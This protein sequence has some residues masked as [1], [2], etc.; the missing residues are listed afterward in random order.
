MSTS[1]NKSTSG[2]WEKENVS[3]ELS[4]KPTVFSVK[5]P[6]LIINDNVY[7][8]GFKSEEETTP[9]KTF[10]EMLYK[11]ISKVGCASIVSMYLGEL[12]VNNIALTSL[13][14]FFGEKLFPILISN[15]TMKYV[16]QYY[17][18]HM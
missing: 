12:N 16:Y 5:F 2:E 10:N 13:A 8:I 1:L 17:L 6:D 4:S 7:K 18:N 15:Y 11:H 3:K 9:P 14:Y